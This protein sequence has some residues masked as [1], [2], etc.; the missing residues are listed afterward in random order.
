MNIYER[1]NVFKKLAAKTSTEVR[2]PTSTEAYTADN[3][4]ATITGGAGEGDTS[5][6]IYLTPPTTDSKTNKNVP[7]VSPKK[8]ML[9]FDMFERLAAK[10]SEV[11]TIRLGKFAA[12][13]EKVD[14]YIFQI[15]RW[16]GFL[17][18][19]SKESVEGLVSLRSKYTETFDPELEHTIIKQLPKLEKDVIT[20]AKQIQN[21]KFRINDFLKAVQNNTP[22]VPTAPNSK[23]QI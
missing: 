1:L 19:I 22:I 6:T 2:S 14:R 15:E 3:F 23:E 7:N 10:K 17:S 8:S 5:V 11:E 4:T 20:S 12:L 18:D 9:D 16:L 21:I 13:K